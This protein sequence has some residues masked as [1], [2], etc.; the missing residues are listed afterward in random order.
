[1]NILA[2]LLPF[3]HLFFMTN[4]DIDD[5]LQNHMIL[6]TGPSL[7]RKEM[8]KENTEKDMHLIP[9]KKIFLSS[10]DPQNSDLLFAG[11]KPV[12]EL[13]EE[14]GKQLDCLNCI[15]TTIKNVV[16]DPTCTDEDII[17]FKHESLY[18]NDIHLFR[19]AVGKILSGHDMV[20]RYWDPD[21]FYMTDAF[22]LK[23]SAARELLKNLEEVTVLDEYKFCEDYFTKVIVSALPK[24]YQINY[25]HFTRKDTEL[26]FFHIPVAGE[27]NWEGYWDKENYDEIYH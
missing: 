5:V 23:I 26:G 15:I 14:R 7:G 20:V 12:W 6:C 13:L 11:E 27:E 3:S 9:F 18:I 17:L 1:M 22:L 4:P 8:L 16:N 19:K 24:V 10:N 25:S 21:G 2:L